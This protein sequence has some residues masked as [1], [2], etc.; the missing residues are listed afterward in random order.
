VTMAPP[1]MQLTINPDAISVSSPSPAC[2]GKR[3]DHSRVRTQFSS[4]R[5]HN[6]DQ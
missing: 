6:Y 4:G 2:G 5:Q 1:T 3:S